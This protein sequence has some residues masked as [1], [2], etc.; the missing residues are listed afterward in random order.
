MDITVHRSAGGTWHATKELVRAHAARGTAGAPSAFF[1]N[2]YV[3]M[4]VMKVR[5]V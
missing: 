3:T 4:M 5:K 2:V 1:Q